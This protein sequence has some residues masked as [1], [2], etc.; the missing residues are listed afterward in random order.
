MQCIQRHT[1]VL[2]LAEIHVGPQKGF[3]NCGSKVVY[4]CIRGWH[5]QLKIPTN[6]Q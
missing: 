3:V 5:G 4:G 6:F 2:C 1:G